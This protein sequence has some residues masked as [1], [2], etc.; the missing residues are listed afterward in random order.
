MFVHV[1]P[2]CQILAKS[3]STLCRSFNVFLPRKVVCILIYELIIC[4]MKVISFR[5]LMLREA[6][7]VIENQLELP[8]P[9]MKR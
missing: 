3:C 5:T 4:I 6:F 9:F 7:L 8:F 2:M 1:I